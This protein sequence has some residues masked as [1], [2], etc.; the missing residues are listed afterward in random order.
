MQTVL[1][2]KENMESS[3]C[4]EFLYHESIFYS[5]GPDP[6]IYL[7]NIYFESIL[8]QRLWKNRES[9]REQHVVFS[10][11]ELQSSGRREDKK[12]RDVQTVVLVRM[13]GKTRPMAQEGLRISLGGSEVTS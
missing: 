1:T 4:M 3:Q 10:L 5:Y 7:I 13:W 2:G 9:Y 11:E 8:G 6:L 12:T